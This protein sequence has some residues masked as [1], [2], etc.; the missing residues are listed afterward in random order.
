MQPD[1][2]RAIIAWLAEEQKKL[3]KDLAR[4]GFAAH[5]LAQ[6]EP[7][8]DL[9]I[10]SLMDDELPYSD[11]W[12]R[13]KMIAD[14][15]KRTEDQ[16]RSQFP[17]DFPKIGRRYDLSQK[18]E[19]FRSR[20]DIFKEIVEKVESTKMWTTEIVVNDPVAVVKKFRRFEGGS[21]AG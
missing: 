4:H 2:V 21:D 5:L 17:P 18:P 20:L 6:N 14:W 1:E 7:L 12:A 13:L 8:G 16:Y 10:L 19:G 11:L 15:L 3:V 9:V